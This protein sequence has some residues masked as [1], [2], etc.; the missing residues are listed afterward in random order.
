MVTVNSRSGLE[1]WGGLAERPASSALSLTLHRIALATGG[2]A[3]A[4]AFED[5]LGNPTDN[6]IRCL[7]ADELLGKLGLEVFEIRHFSFAI[8]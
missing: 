5:F 2:D 8:G 1:N 3:V 6:G 4:I 7:V